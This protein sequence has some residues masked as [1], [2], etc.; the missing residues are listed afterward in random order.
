M[1]NTTSQIWNKG[2]SSKVNK[3]L[4]EENPRP[5]N[6][7]IHKV[8][9]NPEVYQA[10]PKS[11][12][13]RD[14]RSQG[15][16]AALQVAAVP[17]VRMIDGL[18]NGTLKDK[19]NDIAQMAFVSLSMVSSANAQLNQM[20][21]EAIKLVLNSK[22]RAICSEPT[23]PSRLSFGDNLAERCKA[24]PRRPLIGVGVTR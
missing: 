22:Y 3:K 20:R 14:V 5:E 13:Q 16:Q 9:L 17:L 23:T 12:Q 15:V 19:S 11:Y 8:M 2:R 21:Q 1:A 4:R 10:V 24:A 7:Q 18:K 6:V